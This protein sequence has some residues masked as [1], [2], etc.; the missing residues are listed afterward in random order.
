VT[1]QRDRPVIT[2]AM[3]KAGKEVVRSILGDEA[4]IRN[5]A[6]KVARNV[7]LAMTRH[8]EFR[9]SDEQDRN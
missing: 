6:E 5:E 1:E 4:L 2:P 8:A 9:E 3:L 7:Y